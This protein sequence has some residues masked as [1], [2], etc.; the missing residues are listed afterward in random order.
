M[1]PE[2]YK[3]LADNASREGKFD[4][5][6]Y[7]ALMGIL[8]SILQMQICSHGTRGFCVYCFFNEFRSNLP[9]TTQPWR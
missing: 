2:E 9:I 1:L 5:A 4:R 3:S 7:Y 8:E 6:Q